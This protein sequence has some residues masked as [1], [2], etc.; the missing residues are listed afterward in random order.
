MTFILTCLFLLS[1]LKEVLT[2]IL[3][4]DIFGER[5]ANISIAVNNQNSNLR[6]SESHFLKGELS[7]KLKLHH[8]ETC[9]RH[10]VL[11]SCGHFSTSL[12]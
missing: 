4:F 5:K 9:V 12:R 8:N 2:V 6:L 3:D 10:A 7:E 11:A 1:C